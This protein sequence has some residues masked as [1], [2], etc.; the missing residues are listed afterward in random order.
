MM[1]GSVLKLKLQNFRRFVET[2]VISFP[3]GL[4]VISGSNGA[5]K[6]TLVESFT[7]ALFG[8]KRGR[9][10]MALALNPRSD[11]APG[12]I[13]VECELFI[14]GQPVKIV[15]SSNSAALWVNNALQ[16]QSI[17]S[18]LSMANRQISALLGGITREQFES[19]YVALQGDTAGLVS[20]KPEVRRNIIEKV[21][22]LEVLSRAVQIQAKR[23]NEAG[24]DVLA[25]GNL[26]CD[27]QSLT[28]GLPGAREITNKLSRP[29]KANYE[30]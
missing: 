20:D 28:D 27:E 24:S 14:D 3:P 19:T 29:G 2:D 15:R 9:G 17:S 8:Q 21:L 26:I 5:G 6:S 16:V 7:Y 10:A 18:S 1:N 4:T 25:Q 30:A 12:D 23:C 11:N 13:H 22:Q